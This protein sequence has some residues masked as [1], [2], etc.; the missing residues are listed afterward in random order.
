MVSVI[1]CSDDVMDLVDMVGLVLVVGGIED[2]ASSLVVRRCGVLSTSLD[3]E[4]LEVVAAAVVT[5]LNVV[6]STASVVGA[7]NVVAS[8]AATSSSWK[9]N[10]GCVFAYSKNSFITTYSK[11]DHPESVR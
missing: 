8:S 5:A 4:G 9:A 10:C 11:R 3:V 7:F 2:E 1:R 6:L